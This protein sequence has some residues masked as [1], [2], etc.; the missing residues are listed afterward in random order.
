[1][2]AQ[3]TV[4]LPE[5]LRSIAASGFIG[6]YQALGSPLANSARLLKFVNNT[7]QLVTVSWDGVH[8]HDILPSDSFALYD[9]TSNRGNPSPYLAAAQGTQFYVKSAS[10]SGS[11]YL[12]ALYAYTNTQGAL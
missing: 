7:N 1:M 9:L 8:D 5:T 2:G 4:M 10:G 12:I 6:S 11:F 3:S